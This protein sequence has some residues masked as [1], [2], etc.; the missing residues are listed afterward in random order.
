MLT[1]I[2]VRNEPATSVPNVATAS[3]PPVCLLAL[4]SPPASP[5]CAGGSESSSR[6]VSDGSAR[7]RSLRLFVQFE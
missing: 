4:N 7:C 5:A 1:R 6:N 2:P 3:A